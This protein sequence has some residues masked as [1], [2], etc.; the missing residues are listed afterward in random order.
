[1][2]GSL[3]WGKGTAF[4]DWMQ[5]MDFFWAILPAPGQNQN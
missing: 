5:K 3:N 1:M 4:F 2:G